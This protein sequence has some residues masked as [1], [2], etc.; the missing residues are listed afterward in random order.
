MNELLRRTSNY[1]SPSVD[2]TRTFYPAM[3]DETIVTTPLAIFE[4][5]SSR[6]MLHE[7]EYSAII[8]LQLSQQHCNAPG[9]S[10]AVASTAVVAGEESAHLPSSSR[11]ECGCTST[12]EH[13][14]GSVT[15]M[16]AAERLLHLPV[17]T[18]EH[19][20]LAGK[21]GCDD[22]GDLP[23]SPSTSTLTSEMSFTE[24]FG[25]P[26][27]RSSSGGSD[28]GRRRRKP[29]PF[30]P[31]VIPTLT[32]EALEVETAPHDR[33][34]IKRRESRVEWVQDSALRV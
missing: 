14:A 22:A 26:S 6:E 20:V 34:E 32:P 29:P 19:F 18:V 15:G 23:G 28:F 24:S 9:K 8:P 1:V 21:A 13:S 10:R 7:L 31:P 33:M 12:C 3:V 30:L 25:T 17:W 4:G 5:P 27:A 16:K 2:R 11:R